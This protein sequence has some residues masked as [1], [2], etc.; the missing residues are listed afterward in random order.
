V[1]AGAPGVLEGDGGDRG[2]REQHLAI[3]GPVD[4]DRVVVDV[5][6]GVAIALVEEVQVQ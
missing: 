3:E 1:I 6:D 5:G 2:L 4:E